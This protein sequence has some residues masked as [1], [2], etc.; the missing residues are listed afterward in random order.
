MAQANFLDRLQNLVRSNLLKM[1]EGA[2]NPVSM[3]HLMRA[4]LDATITKAEKELGPVMASA[5]RAQRALQTNQ[6]QVDLWARRKVSAAQ[7]QLPNRVAT[8]VT[9]YNRY[10]AIQTTLDKSFQ[11]A[12]NASDNLEKSIQV[13]RDKRG[14][15]DARITGI[16][17]MVG[18]AAATE[19]AAAAQ[20]IIDGA[21]TDPNALAKW[22]EQAQFK[23]DTATAHLQIQTRKSDDDWGDGDEPEVQDEVAELM[24]QYA[25]PTGDDEPGAAAAA[26]TYQVTVK[27][28]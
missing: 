3:A 1:L 20:Q 7:S 13:L 4:D 27:P 25:K 12:Q 24:A 15:I 23:L 19:Q 17:S 6:V 5:S 2:E 26:S 10:V 18:S 11:T 14:E 16:E 28:A 21:A 8:A 9:T 22:E